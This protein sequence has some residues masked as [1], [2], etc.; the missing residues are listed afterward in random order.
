MKVKSVSALFVVD[1]S[2][3]KVLAEATAV[4]FSSTV[5]F[6][7]NRRII[8]TAVSCTTNDREPTCARQS[9]Y[10]LCVLNIYWKTRLF[11]FC[12]CC[13]LQTLPTAA[14]RMLQACSFASLFFSCFYPFAKK[15]VLLLC[16]SVFGQM[17]QRLDGEESLGLQHNK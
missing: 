5:S 8:K 13:T 10:I 3:Q 4:F 1:N 14:L 11:F 6:S 2:F 17:Y 15:C 12:A 7:L 9:V 16:V